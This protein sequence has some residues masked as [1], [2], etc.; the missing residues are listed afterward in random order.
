MHVIVD[1]GVLRFFE[2]LQ[3]EK[4]KATRACAHFPLYFEICTCAL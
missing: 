1:C 2:I 4:R 3:S